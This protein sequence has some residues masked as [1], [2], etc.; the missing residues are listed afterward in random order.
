MPD[1]QI[2]YD[3]MAMRQLVNIDPF[4]AYTV[5]RHT[6]DSEEQWLRLVYSLEVRSDPSL[7]TRYCALASSASHPR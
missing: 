4:L 7:R 3:T 6:Y 1:Q 2:E 5:V